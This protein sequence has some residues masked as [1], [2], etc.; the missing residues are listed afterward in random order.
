M[1]LTML[2]NEFFDLGAFKLRKG[3]KI[4]TLIANNFQFKYENYCFIPLFGTTASYYTNSIVI[5]LRHYLS[6]IVL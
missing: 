3:V 2:S 5:I 1:F 6:N 4:I